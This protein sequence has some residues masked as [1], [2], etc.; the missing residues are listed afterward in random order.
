LSASSFEA[1]VRIFYLADIRFPIER[2]NGIQTIESCY[3]L[4]ERDH[5][6]L[7]FVRPD[8]AKPP[9]D[10]FEFYGLAPQARLRVQR[11]FMLGAS[12]VRRAAYLAQA[13]TAVARDRGRT[14]VVITRDLG[15][16]SIVLRLPRRLRPPLVYESHGFAPVFAETMPE[17]LS[18]G[19]AASRSKV[20]RLLVREERVWRHAE[21]YITIS[22]GLAVDLA[23]RFG[24]RET[25]ATIPDGVRIE[26]QRRFVPPR[27]SA[28]PVV[29]Y[30]GHLYPWKG[31]DVLLHA[32]ALLP[33]VRGVIV[34]GHPAESDLARLQA[35][36]NTLGIE[37]RVIFAG[38]VHR[39]KV[40]GFL[41][42]ADVVVMPHTATPVSERYSS[43]LKLFEYMAI[44]KPI[45][46]SDMSSIR[47]V[48]RDGENAC[49]VRSSDPASLASGIEKV[50]TDQQFA[51]RIARKAFEE[52]PAY[53]WAR[54][55]ERLE[56]LLEVVVKRT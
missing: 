42:R 4:A 6:V 30:A 17:L 2:A 44:G 52:A 20:R 9:R 32:V 40:A 33:Q 25:L 48:L 11:A 46:A 31:V 47:E 13:L 14:D 18:G 28:S 27:Q 26:P 16:A 41:E 21:G 51:E 54:R 23:G 12:P 5:T 34:G 56:A 29:A 22:D 15:A 49:L 55:A 36:A 53:T 50:L 10:P 7:L 39:S 45:V 8:T 19:V 1:K 43:P 35:L 24:V 37:D 3:A 38:F